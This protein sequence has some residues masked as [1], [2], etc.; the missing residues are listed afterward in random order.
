MNMYKEGLPEIVV[1]LPAFNR[2]LEIGTIVI[3][4]KCY[5]DRVIVIN[6]GGSDQCAEVA[7]AGGA[8]V[9]HVF[10]RHK[11]KFLTKKRD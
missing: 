5:A 8:E 11:Q 3:I 10:C 4:A 7:E 6:N 2:E 1:I 9:I